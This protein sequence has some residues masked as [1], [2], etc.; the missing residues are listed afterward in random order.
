PLASGVSSSSHSI[1][2]TPNIS[3]ESMLTIPEANVPRTWR[4]KCPISLSEHDVPMDQAEFQCPFEPTIVK[5][6]GGK[7]MKIIN[8]LN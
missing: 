3:K 6:P 4:A 2:T 7:T 8:V 5:R 1:E